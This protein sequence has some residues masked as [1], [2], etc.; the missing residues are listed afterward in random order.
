MPDDFESNHSL[1][2]IV[3]DGTSCNTLSSESV[4]ID[5]GQYTTRD[6]HSTPDFAGFYRKGET[7]EELDKAIRQP[8]MLF[9]IKPP[10]ATVDNMYLF[11]DTFGHTAKEHAKWV[12][13]RT[14]DQVNRQ[15]RH[16]FIQF[17]DIQTLIVFI[18]S[19]PIFQ[20]FVANIQDKRGKTRIESDIYFRPLHSNPE[21]LFTIDEKGEPKDFTRQFRTCWR[22]ACIEG[23]M[24]I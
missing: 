5:P 4:D 17:P 20:F 10:R 2:A 15:L 6:T 23:K 1:S 9:E 24:N 22:L 19:G 13:S 18:A 16:S 8:W 3:S 7:E 14:I 21:R 11:E 12:I